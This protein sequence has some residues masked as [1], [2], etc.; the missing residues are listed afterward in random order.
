DPSPPSRAGRPCTSTSSETAV[1]H[2]DES[3]LR[4]R[5]AVS[6][7]GELAVR[8]TDATQEKDGEEPEKEMSFTA[9]AGCLL[10]GALDDRHEA[11][12]FA[13]AVEEWRGGAAG[14]IGSS[15]WTSRNC[16]GPDYKMPGRLVKK[17]MEGTST[18]APPRGAYW[19]C[20]YCMRVHLD[21]LRPAQSRDEK[22][23]CGSACQGA[24]GEELRQS[25]A[26]QVERRTQRHLLL[27]HGC[28]P[29][30][31]HQDG[32]AGATDLGYSPP[33]RKRLP[34]AD[35][36]SPSLIASEGHGGFV[37]Q[38]G[39]YTGFQPCSTGLASSCRPYRTF[40]GSLDSHG[41]I[42]LCWQVLDEAHLIVG[43][44]DGIA[45]VWDTASSEPKTVLCHTHVFAE[46]TESGSDKAA[47]ALG[48]VSVAYYGGYIA[49]GASDGVVRI[50]KAMNRVAH[51]DVLF[52]KAIF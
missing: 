12:R 8:T 50:W 44:S 4:R 18:D 23:F 1:E 32:S 35:P 15:F 45:A 21:T 9:A 3:A 42:V 30:P 5:E 46:F 31:M 39:I 49:T 2:V 48:V 17:A 33:R 40:G 27:S 38:P 20:Y 47:P 22:A 34:V 28:P 26:R 10:D 6:Q 52:V 14:R 16:G 25:E 24:Y 41:G 7:R 13:Q 36:P 43:T 29:T 19:C 51:E 11:A 37:C